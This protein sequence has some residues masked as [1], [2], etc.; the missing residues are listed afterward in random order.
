MNN[1]QMDS[2]NEIQTKHLPRWLREAINKSQSGWLGPEF[3]Y[4]TFQ[5]R[6][7][8]VTTA[9]SH[10]VAQFLFRGID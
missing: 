1:G 9:P 2:G 3:E 4:R 7:Q 8:C 10:L 6:V 5:V